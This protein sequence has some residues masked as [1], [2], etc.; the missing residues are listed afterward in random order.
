MLFTLDLQSVGFSYR[1]LQKDETWRDITEDKSLKPSDFTSEMP[2]EI[3]AR[4]A[5]LGTTLEIDGTT[6]DIDPN[7]W[8]TD[9]DQLSSSSSVFRKEWPAEPTIGQ[10]KQTIEA[11]DDSKHNNLILNVEGKFVLRQSPPFNQL[12]NDPSIV[13]RHESFSAGNG[14]VGRKAS[15]DAKYINDL[16]VSSLE[17]WRDHLIDHKTHEYSDEHATQTLHEIQQELQALQEKWKGDY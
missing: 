5:K 3:T 16:F 13:V 2:S 15:Q 7:K 10:L 1:R 6:Y 11:G 4:S 9:H 8:P 12:V 14:Y 17:H